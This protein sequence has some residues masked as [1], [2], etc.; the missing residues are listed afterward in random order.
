M[1]TNDGGPAYPCD[2]KDFQPLTGEQVV[3]E[4][5]PGMSL[6]DWFAGMALQGMLSANPAMMPEVSDKNVDA[7]LAREAYASADAMIAERNK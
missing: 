6:R 3:R 4:Q 2:W 1:K 7:V 5:F